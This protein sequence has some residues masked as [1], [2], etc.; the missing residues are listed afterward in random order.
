MAKPIVVLYLNHVD[1]FGPNLSPGELMALLN[2]NHSDK[3]MAP[4]FYDYLWFVFVNG[5]LPAPELKVFH[6]K[7]FT[8]A[9]YDDLYKMLQDGINELKQNKE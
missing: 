2:D 3:K 5:E 4:M 1:T 6:E 8:K 9:Q 7:D